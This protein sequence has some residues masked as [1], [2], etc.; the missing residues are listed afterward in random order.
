[1]KSEVLF[2][3]CQVIIGGAQEEISLEQLRQEVNRD[4][5][6]EINA[7]GAEAEVDL[8]EVTMRVQS[9]M[10]SRGNVKN[11]PPAGKLCIRHSK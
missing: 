11:S 3:I 2:T 5:M 9:K 4:V 10:T 7:L 1:M 6:A 8:D